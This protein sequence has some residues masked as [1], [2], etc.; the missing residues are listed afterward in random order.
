M[1]SGCPT[2]SVVEQVPDALQHAHLLVH[3]CQLPFRTSR[4]TKD[5]QH[6]KAEHTQDS[7]RR[8]FIHKKAQTDVEIFQQNCL[9]QE[10]NGQ[11]D[12]VDNVHKKRLKLFENSKEMLSLRMAKQCYH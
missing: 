5:E 7:N 6:Y 8:V 4:S 11:T 9:L 12:I 2:D 1:E 3:Y 10:T